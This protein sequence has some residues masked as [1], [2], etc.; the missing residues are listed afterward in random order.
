MTTSRS[1]LAGS[2]A[3]A[4]YSL[5]EVTI[6]FSL[7]ATL[8][9]LVTNFALRGS[10]AQ[11]FLD[12]MSRV[13]EVTQELA[14]EMREELQ[15]SVRLFSDDALGQAY[16]AVLDHGTLLPNDDSVE[17]PAL[18]PSGIFELEANAGDVTG[19]EL[20]FARYAW[21]TEFECTSGNR[22][23]I[24]VLRIIH[25]YMSVA[26]GGPQ[27]GSPIG[28]NMTKFVSEPL[29]SAE[30]VDS[31]TDLTDQREVLEHLRDGTADVDGVMHPP[32]NVVWR[33]A[34]D[35]S[36]VGTFRQISATTALVDVPEAP[37]PSGAWRVLADE[38]LSDDGKLFFRH[39]SIATNFAPPVMQ[40]GQ[41]GVLD[42]SRGPI[43]FPHGFEVQIIGP[44][45]ARKV[46]VR[47]VLTT[48]NNKGR[49][50]FYSIE[51]VADCRDI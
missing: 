42:N 19:N 18:N 1:S 11:Q 34:A 49:K 15:S 12:R 50:P 33:T 36:A 9:G 46:L 4:G 22:Y 32:A 27:A 44:A 28:M 43:G 48:T 39:H 40:I 51:L 3:D 16:L 38:R 13:T 2:R 23:R 47:L 35:P 6:S 26:G 14:A 5:L 25:Y 8:A 31:I 41:F 45:S 7:L 24:D 17:L 21:T 10:E 30:Q 20:M 29:V 37:R